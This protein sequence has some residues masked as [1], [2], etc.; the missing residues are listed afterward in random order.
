ML[1]LGAWSIAAQQR[2]VTIS[3]ASVTE[4]GGNLNVRMLVDAQKV[5]VRCNG[6]Y[7]LVPYIVKDDVRLKLPEV[8]YMGSQRGKFDRRKEFLSGGNIPEY[9][10]VFPNAN[11][12]KPEV[13]DYIVAV[14]RMPWMENARV[15]YDW[16]VSDCGGDT[17][18]WTD[19]IRQEK[20]VF[21]LP[22][23]VFYSPEP[24]TYRDPQSGEFVAGK[25]RSVSAELYIQ[26][27]Q[28]VPDIREDFRYNFD[29][30]RKADSLMYYILDN[31]LMSEVEMS[32]HGYA[33]PEGAL[34]RNKNLSRYRAQ[35]LHKYLKAKFDISGLP[36][37]VEW[38]PVDWDGLRSILAD[39]NFPYGDD[40][41][42]IID[43]T[44]GDEER[45]RIIAGV[46]GKKVHERLLGEVYPR[47]RRTVLHAG[48]T[49]A[50]LTPEQAR[51]ILHTNP[52]LLSLE[53]IYSIA[54]SY[55]EGSYEYID[56]FLAAARQF[57]N[58][59]VANNN[60]A[61]VL[62]RSG[63]SREAYKYLAKISGDPRAYTNIGIYYYLEGDTEGAKDYFNK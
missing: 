38:T 20:S 14:P 27:P 52:E 12:R 33:S 1:F 37:T 57:P 19:H 44:E 32:I 11:R 39:G 61:A 25:R 10:K 4:S 13:V 34:W 5:D 48:F 7:R 40:I 53:E 26:F 29:E 18:L 45:E 3:N 17:V 50:E 21:E 56:V 59:F 36:L 41:V 63:S 8:V 35:N 47:L 16:V 23:V 24:E 22:E 15:C 30:L 62:L 31:K 46:A 51:D 55:E 49:V 58:D 28:D 60:A 2:A 43:N 9:Y 6:S 42:G 54:D